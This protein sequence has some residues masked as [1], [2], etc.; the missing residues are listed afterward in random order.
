MQ[1]QAFNSQVSFATTVGPALFADRLHPQFEKPASSFSF[2]VRLSLDIAFVGVNV[3]S[4]VYVLSQ[5]HKRDMDD[6]RP[7]LRMIVCLAGGTLG[8]G[9]VY[10]LV[11]LVLTLH[12]IR[13]QVAARDL[14]RGATS[15]IVHKVDKKQRILQPPWTSSVSSPNRLF[16]KTPG[17]RLHLAQCVLAG[18]RWLSGFC[19]APP[20]AITAMLWN[21]GW[22]LAWAVS[23]FFWSPTT[24]GHWTFQDVP[25][26]FYLLQSMFLT[27]ATVD[28]L[29]KFLR[30]V[31]LT[32]Y[33]MSIEFVVDVVTLP[34]ITLVLSQSSFFG[35]SDT[36]GLDDYLLSVGWI[37][38]IRAF[39]VVRFVRDVVLAR[40]S[41]AVGFICSLLLGLAISIVAFASAMFTF[42]GALTDFD[43]SSLRL[44]TFIY[45]AIVTLSTVGYGDLAP[46]TILGR[47][48]TSLY[49][50]TILV[51]VPSQ[52]GQLFD[53]L[54]TKSS[55][56]QVGTLPSL[57]R[58]KDRFVVLCGHVSSAQLS[59]FMYDCIRLGVSHVRK[60]LVLTD[61]PKALYQQ[62]IREARQC[63]FSLCIRYA[64]L[65]LGGNPE[66]ERDSCI[67][68]TARAIFVLCDTASSDW[69]QNDR[70]AITR[71]LALR[72]LGVPMRRVCVQFH[73]H[74]MASLAQTLGV[75]HIVILEAYR[76]ALLA[77]SCCSCPGL[78]TLM[79]NLISGVVTPMTAGRN[80]KTVSE[81]KLEYVSGALCVIRRFKIPVSFYNTSFPV[82]ACYIFKAHGALLIGVERSM[83]WTPGYILYP[84]IG[85]DSFFFKE[86]DYGILITRDYTLSSTLET[87]T[88]K[89]STLL[90][91]YQMR[92]QDYYE[93]TE[94]TW[95]H[96]AR[97]R[98]ADD[99]S[100]SLDAS[101]T[102]NFAFEKN[103]A[104]PPI[105]EASQIDLAASCG[106]H[107]SLLVESY[108]EAVH[109]RWRNS[110][111]PFILVCG[112]MQ[113][114]QSL[115]S[116]ICGEPDS[117]NVMVLQASA[118]S[119]VH[120]MWAG[121]G[122]DVCSVILGESI[123]P[124][125]LLRAGVLQATACLILPQDLID[126]QAGTSDVQEAAKVQDTSVIVVHLMIRQLLAG[127]GLRL[128]STFTHPSD[129]GH[130]PCSNLVT[131]ATTPYD[132]PIT[133][134]SDISHVY[135][136]DVST[137]QEDPIEE[138]PSFVYQT[139]SL[140]TTGSVY[141]DSLLF[142]LVAHSPYLSPYFVDSLVFQLLLGLSVDR[143]P[144][145]RPSVN[146]SCDIPT[147][148]NNQK[149]IMLVQSNVTVPGGE[150]F[151]DIF[152][153][154]L[155]CEGRLAL[156]LF[157][158]YADVNGCA[159]ESP[160]KRGYVFTCPVP[161]IRVLKQD[162]VYIL[163]PTMLTLE[164]RGPFLPGTASVYPNSENSDAG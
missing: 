3:G 51:W 82:V 67:L 135:F 49:I 109:T 104:S 96:R 150:P 74:S 98:S 33:I 46:Q 53:V 22:C 43:G 80:E 99:K 31:E 129:N 59:L 103:H 41:Q 133:V 12:S 38:W 1:T 64:E 97:V 23:T 158:P 73:T 42:E 32:N 45:F 5:S 139:S 157:R 83:W 9:F 137:A 36:F 15:L 115:I 145:R 100:V 149:G 138:T 28:I 131:A 86:G 123:S 92:R 101:P 163:E 20:Y 160:R 21:I 148:V 13:T 2:C 62:Q 71:L 118:S 37:R 66:N 30:H 56:Q 110:E 89:N 52:L 26:I 122:S 164:S 142:R 84:T 120:S 27:G 156:G 88:D 69:T 162:Q 63:Q 116:H 147:V 18:R 128:L 141:A 159:S 25:V 130:N 76:T 153:R 119:F 113:D 10:Y 54:G 35:G 146:L 125:N 75:R 151:L 87:V 126:T 91:Q 155:L 70:L 121:V 47:C 58:H 6:L 57:V 102:K 61:R 81:D 107:S 78:I 111:A 93:D 152:E 50:V 105:N 4:L 108:Y 144:Q 132:D 55:T 44:I 48:C 143:C 29:L 40:E 16:N 19:I 14:F 77:K 112:W 17:Y 65:G 106:D 136:V 60:L 124:V 117:F 85:S 95:K 34:P 127:Y 94:C 90:H 161:Q 39:V 154:F 72:H 140:Y 114:F 8:F 79:G 7:P 24:E 68:H 134:F 11:R